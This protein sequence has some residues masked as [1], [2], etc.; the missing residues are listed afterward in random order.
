[1]LRKKLLNA[2]EFTLGFVASSEAGLSFVLRLPVVGGTAGARANTSAYL[3]RDEEHHAKLAYL[4]VLIP[5]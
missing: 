4:T 5:C 2:I 1:M 3:S